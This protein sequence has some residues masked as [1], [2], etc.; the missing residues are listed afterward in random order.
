MSIL[1]NRGGIIMLVQNKAALEELLRLETK[2]ID[3]YKAYKNEVESGEM[4]KMCEDIINKHNLHIETL[5]KYVE[6]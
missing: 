4:Q 6:R 2:I 1:V 5:Q 3:K